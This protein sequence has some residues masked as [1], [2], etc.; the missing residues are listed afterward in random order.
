MILVSFDRPAM[1]GLQRNADS[2]DDIAGS[3]YCPSGFQPPA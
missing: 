2:G 1:K 3:E